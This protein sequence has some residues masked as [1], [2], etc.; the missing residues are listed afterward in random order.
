MHV[1]IHQKSSYDDGT[2]SLI[3][4]NDENANDNEAPH[5]VFGGQND[6]GRLDDEGGD[7][8]Q[9]W[10]QMSKTVEKSLCEQ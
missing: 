10:G 8:N 5:Y 3:E 9:G 6:K 4:G 7:N 1:S 2:F